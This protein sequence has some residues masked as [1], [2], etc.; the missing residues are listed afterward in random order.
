MSY[1]SYFKNV[2][3]GKLNKIRY[4]GGG[5]PAL[6]EYDSMPLKLKDKVVELIGNPYKAVKYNQF[7]VLL[8]PDRVAITFFSN[9]KKP[10][11]HYLRTETAKQYHQNAMFLNALHIV[12]QN[13]TARRKTLGG[14]RVGIW[15]NLTKIT[16]ELK[17][18]F[19]HSLPGAEFRLRN[20]YKKYRDNSY[21]S[22][23]HGNTGNSNSRKVTEML[24][25]LILA[26]Y[27]RD[28]KPYPNMVND[29]YMRFLSG[30][31]TLF[32]KA[33][34]EVFDR[35][36]FVNK[37]GEF[38]TISDSVI[39]DYINAPKN[40]PVLDSLRNDFHYYN[41]KQRPHYHRHSPNFSGSKISLDD[42]DLP[43]VYSKNSK[44]KLTTSRVK[45]YYA[46]DVVSHALIGV[47]YSKKK[48]AEL[49]LDCLR[50][51]FQFLHRNNVGMPMEMEVEHHLVSKYKNDLMKSGELFS[52][53]HFC[54][55]GNSQEKR[56]E[57]FNKEKKYGFE[58][59]Y[60]DG[61]GRF[62]LS[63]ANRPKQ[64][65][66]WDDDGMHA[67][68]KKHTFE[69]L[70]ADDLWIQEQYNNGLHPNQTKYKGQ[71]RMQVF[72]DN[73]N[74]DMVK[75]SEAK[76]AKFVG[77][78][79]K[80]SIRRNQ[81]VVAFRDKFV[82]PTPEVMAFLKP[83]NKSVTAFGLP[84][85]NG[86]INQVHLYQDENFIASCKQLQTYNEAI[87]ERTEID[88]EIRTEQAKYISKYDKMVRD[89]RK[90]LQK[91]E[92]IKNDFEDL[93]QTVE[94]HKPELVKKEVDEWGSFG[95]GLDYSNMAEENL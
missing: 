46:Y 86:I 1:D 81:Y 68:F 43:R 85:E 18:E 70:V 65:K 13:A 49:F 9:Y 29:T 66:R 6:I 80:T 23:I 26:I 63:E 17:D 11:G 24:E 74:Q 47:A 38:I 79:V 41:N 8:V 22:L 12:S 31:D 30:T 53:V 48:D 92:I 76:V 34:G 78:S 4:G 95:S 50:N 57:H 54:A 94:I 10:N 88:N 72:L 3:R 67:Y 35:S 7:R 2:K 69:E 40:R 5:H 84:N 36:N 51:M 16:A 52:H 28:N 55:A 14:R 71:S 39:R 58:K 37:K 77:L 73:L 45:T 15:K 75:Y 59:R 44:G 87:A 93:A 25:R 60:H 21:I 62:Y 42:R 83:N 89:A 27:V 56:A 61:V 20:V 33:T 90:K 32:D 64:S 91:I 19:G 82:L